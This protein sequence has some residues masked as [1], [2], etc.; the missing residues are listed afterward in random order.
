MFIAE[1]VNLDLSQYRTSR[2]GVWNVKIPMTKK[3][4][5]QD[6]LDNRLTI[7]DDY[8]ADVRCSQCEQMDKLPSTHPQA[9]KLYQ[10][11]AHYKRYVCLKC[12]KANKDKEKNK[13]KM[14]DRTR[15]IITGQAI[16]LAVETTLQT[17]DTSDQKAFFKEVNK[18]Q[19]LYEKYIIAEKEKLNNE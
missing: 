4:I 15:E 1:L 10:D 2:Q 3:I 18:W 8:S 11:P 7:Y 5:Q 14:D 13:N 9:S 17:M 6:V 12:W 19:K 16:N